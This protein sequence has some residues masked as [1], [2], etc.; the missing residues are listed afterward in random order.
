M[1]GYDYDTVV[2]PGEKPTEA[3]FAKLWT[4][5]REQL[6]AEAEV[7]KCEV[8]LK[9]AQQRLKDVQERR[10]PEYM[11][12]SLGMSEYKDPRGRL[13]KIEKV[14][15]ASIAKDPERKANAIKWL[16]EHG[17]GSIVKREIVLSFDREREAWANRVLRNLKRYKEPLDLTLERSV[18]GS[19]LKAWVSD[20][21]AEGHSI[22]FELFGVFE[23]VRA[24]IK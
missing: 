8:A 20:M 2:D 5:V 10:L 11:Q 21:L 15:H 9:A 22:P 6:E 1:S 12:G 4:L 7:K 19:T 24:T 13:I 18:H 23:Q 14:V 16:D 3:A 17:H